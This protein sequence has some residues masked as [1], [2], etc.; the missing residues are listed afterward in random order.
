MQLS[1]VEIYTHLAKLI[2]I[3]E[4]ALHPRNAVGIASHVNGVGSEIDG[5]AQRVFHQAKVFIMG[6]VEWLDSGCDLDSLSDQCELLTS[7]RKTRLRSTPFRHMA[8]GRGCGK[9]RMKT[10]RA[11]PTV[12]CE[13]ATGMAKVANRMP[14]MGKE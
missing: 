6:T 14:K 2:E 13:A 10:A 12:F 5:D 1:V 7:V 4:D 3:R 11:L 9:C 8:G